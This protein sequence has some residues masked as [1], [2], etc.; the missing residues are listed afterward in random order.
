MDAE[1]VVNWEEF[2]VALKVRFTPS[3]FDDPVGAFTKLKQISTVEEYQSQFEILSN[4][5]NGLSEDFR[6]HTFLSE[7][8]DELKIL[9]TMLKPTT[10]P[11]AFGLARLQAEEVLRRNCTYRNNSWSSSSTNYQATQ[12]FYPR[13]TPPPNVPRLPAPN[14]PSQNQNTNPTYPNP[15]NRRPNLPI[16]RV[17]PNQMQERREKGICYFC[18][19]KYQP[20]H[21]C[22]RP[23]LY[24][25]EGQELEAKEDKGE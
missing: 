6:I 19:D 1:P 12:Q 8:K 2:V 20:G 17:T 7:L 15:Y 14:N 16:R 18:D 11:T 4:R 22:N 10:L 25:L 5:I 9:V 13:L 24:L 21:R 23:K 3:A